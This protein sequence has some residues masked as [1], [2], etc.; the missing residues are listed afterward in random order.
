MKPIMQTTLT[1]SPNDTYSY[2]L[3]TLCS[4][5]FQPSI[6]PQISTSS[7]ARTLFSFSTFFN[8]FMLWLLLSMGSQIQRLRNEVSY[9]AGEARDLR[10]YGYNPSSS[11]AGGNREGEC[12]EGT[13]RDGGEKGVKEESAVTL[14]LTHQIPLDDPSSLSSSDK[15]PS[16]V[17]PQSLHPTMPN[18]LTPR[19]QRHLWAGWD[20]LVM[21]P[22]VKS[23]TKGVAWLWH[24]V[25]WLVVPPI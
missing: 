4:I 25:V 7:R 9:V 5:S 23:L 12:L 21:H 11:G 16:T 14:G 10:M 3:S 22:T 24:A 1:P 6:V 20:R 8:L 19:Q 15:L 13:L 2:P 17:S 18:A